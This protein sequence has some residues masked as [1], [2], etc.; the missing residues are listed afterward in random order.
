MDGYEVIAKLK[1]HNKELPI[2]IIT[3]YSDVRN[4]VTTIKMG[5]FDYV[6]KPLFPDEILLTI[7]KALEFLPENSSS[8]L[9]KSSNPKAPKATQVKEF[10]DGKSQAMA[11]VM[12][13]VKIVAPTNISVLIQGETGVGKEYIARAIHNSSERTDPS[14]P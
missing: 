3:G 4:A 7:N 6:T 5:V 13:M 1:E 2:I 9:N 10:I 8:T 11:D 12:N 14:S